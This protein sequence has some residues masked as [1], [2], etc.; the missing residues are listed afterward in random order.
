MIETPEHCRRRG[1][2]Q[3][4]AGLVETHPAD[5]MAILS[6]CLIVRCELRFDTRSFDY[7]ALSPEFDEVPANI[8]TPRYEVVIKSVLEAD[9]DPPQ[10]VTNLVGFQ[11]LT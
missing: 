1:A 6:R 8:R 11:R 9:S 10:Y 3:I 5:V 4:Q 2:F 7:V